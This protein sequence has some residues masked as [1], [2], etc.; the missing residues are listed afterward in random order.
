MKIRDTRADSGRI[1]WFYMSQFP[2]YSF[3]MATDAADAFFYRCRGLLFVVRIYLTIGEHSLD[4]VS[5]IDHRRFRRATN[6]R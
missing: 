1:T 4:D 5:L 3:Y 6:T 2:L